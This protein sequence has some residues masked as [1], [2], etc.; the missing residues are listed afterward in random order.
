MND[1]IAVGSLKMY[2]LVANAAPLKTQEV[3]ERK[4]LW[5]SIGAFGAREKGLLGQGTFQHS[6]VNK[7]IIPI[8]N[9]SCHMSKL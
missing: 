8:P 9:G 2:R 6:P 7:I 5:S 3:L 1:W 4:G